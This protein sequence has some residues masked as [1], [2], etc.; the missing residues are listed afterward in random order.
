[1]KAFVFFSFRV[2]VIGFIFSIKNKNYNEGT[3]K[4][5]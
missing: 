3:K 2:F 4:G 1:M 5:S